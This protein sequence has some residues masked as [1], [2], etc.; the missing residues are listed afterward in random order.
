VLDLGF[1]IDSRRPVEGQL[2]IHSGD[3]S[4]SNPRY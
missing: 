3:K 1:W 4:F 2:I